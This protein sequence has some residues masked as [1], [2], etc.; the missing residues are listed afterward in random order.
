MTQS[1]SSR[2]AMAEFDYDLPSELI[3]QVPL[4]DRSA[5]RL[6]HIERESSSLSDRSFTDLS[7]LL[8]PGDLLVFN[9][10]RVIPARLPGYRKSGG[11]V[12]I[13]LL[14]ARED[15]FWH[16]LIK[17]ARKLVIGECV[18][19]EHLHMAEARSSVEIIEK[20]ED[21][22]AVVR[23][24]DSISA[25]LE[26]YGRVPLPPYIHETLT[27]DE[28]YQTLYAK[29]DGSAA[30]PTAGLHFN[31]QTFTALEER[32]IGV[33]FVTL[34][35]GLDTFRPVT[36]E[37]A[38]DHH[39][40]EEWCSIPAETVAA[41]N[42]AK[43]EGGKIVA[44]GTTSARTLESYGRARNTATEFAGFTDIYITPGYTWQVVDAMVTNFHLPKSTLLLMMSSFVGKEL[45][46]DAYRHA[47]AKRYRF[48]S[49]GD[50]M[51]IT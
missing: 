26:D 28:R 12:E 8:Q 45:L 38:E 14:R 47:I 40:H 46:F 43:A 19:V 32:G 21:G 27:D 48:F 31:D 23:L 35:V 6:L 49:F 4:S 41:I 17:P 39:I 5:S 30:A 25:H 16:A 34:H 11:K 37:F 13:F 33:A 20:H 7:S 44:V 2:L 22:Q 1:R 50:A 51:L 15:S 42:R 18:M 29:Q 9:D 36:A 3:A 24:D 10:S